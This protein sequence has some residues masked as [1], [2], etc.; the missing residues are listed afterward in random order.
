MRTKI[1]L[2]VQTYFLTIFSENILIH[3][4]IDECRINSN[5]CQYMCENQLGSYRCYCPIGFN[6]NHS[7]QCEGLNRWKTFLGKV[8]WNFLDINECEQFQIDCGEDR[9]CFNTRGAYECID[10]P[11]PVG[12]T[13][14]N[15]TICLSKC[16]QRSSCPPRRPTYIHYQFLAIPRLTPVNQTLFTLPIVD[17]KSHSFKLVDRTYSEKSFPFYLNSLALQTNRTL[18]ES[19]E[20]QFE[21]HVYTHD[22]QHHRKF[23]S[24]F[25]RLF[26]LHL[27]V[28]PF[29]F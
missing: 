17:H 8:L 15:R 25:E 5:I 19:N 6:L 12:Y 16:H 22:Q 27:H 2:K 21:I 28:S 26:H 13:R 10:I 29:H 7:G 11:C 23:R 24:R 9:I 14:E 18:L 4:D 1:D 3:L 20:Y